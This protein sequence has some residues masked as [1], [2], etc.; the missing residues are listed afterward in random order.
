MESCATSALRLTKSGMYK[1][2]SLG[3]GLENV[4]IEILNNFFLKYSF[5][6]GQTLT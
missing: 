3:N 6:T 5:Q 1:L 4:Q 2:F